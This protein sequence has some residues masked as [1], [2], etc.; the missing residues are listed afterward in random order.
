MDLSLHL[1]HGLLSL[2]SS[3]AQRMKTILDTFGL[4]FGPGAF[5][6]GGDGRVSAEPA[7]SHRQ[8]M[9]AWP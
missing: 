6:P 3:L 1:L 4:E 9:F 8:L 5:G 7:G 2:V